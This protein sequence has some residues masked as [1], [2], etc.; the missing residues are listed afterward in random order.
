MSSVR[1]GQPI[2]VI[3]RVMLVSQNTVRAAMRTDGP[4]K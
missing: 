2:E 4:P 3:A 1:T